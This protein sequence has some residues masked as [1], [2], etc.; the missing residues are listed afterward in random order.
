VI[1]DGREGTTAAGQEIRS[2]FRDLP[3]MLKDLFNEFRV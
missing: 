2:F 1:V 3:A